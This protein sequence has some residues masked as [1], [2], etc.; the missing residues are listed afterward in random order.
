MA[1]GPDTEHLLNRIA[2]CTNILDTIALRIT[3]LPELPTGLQTLHCSDAHLTSLPKLPATLQKLYCS[4][5]LLTSLPEL[6][7]G[8]QVLSCFN[9]HLTSLPE[10]PTGLRGLEC[11]NISLPI[12]RKEGE[13]ITDYNRR[14]RPIRE[15]EASKKRTQEKTQLLK[16]EIAMAVWHPRKVMRLLEFGVDLEDM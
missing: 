9:T 16:E 2:N 12:Q 10:L 15:E 8:L 7:T 6:P 13:S 4:Y 3:S 14:W 1:H 5:T 11:Y